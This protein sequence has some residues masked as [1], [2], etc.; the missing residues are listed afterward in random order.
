M[1]A[2]GTIFLLGKTRNNWKPILS[3]H[4]SQVQILSLFVQSKLRSNNQQNNTNNHINQHQDF[5]VENPM[6]EKN[7]GTVVHLKTF[8]INK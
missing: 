4:N 7:H 3:N 1:N 5:Y 2:R 6:R 8:T